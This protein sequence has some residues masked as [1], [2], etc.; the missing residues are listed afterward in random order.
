M[1][2]HEAQG[3]D[4]CSREFQIF[5]KPAGARCNLRCCYCYYLEKDAMREGSDRFRM[6]DEVLEE[7]V[8]QH[9]EASRGQEIFFSWHGGE[10]ALAG[11]DFFRSVVAIQ[12]RLVPE[13]CRVLNGMQT[14]ATLIDEAWGRFLREEDFYVGISLDGPERF[15]NSNRKKVDGRGTFAEVMRGLSVL[16][17]HDVP[18]EIL[19]VVNS[20]NA[21]APLEVY[22]FFKSLDASFIT[23]L[24][25]VERQGYNSAGVTARSVRPADFG[26]FLSAIFDEWV[27]ND[28][29]KIKVQIFEEALRTAFGQEHT[30]CIFKPVC[31]AVPVVEMNGDF[32]SCDHFVDEV[33]LIGNIMDSSLDSLL[34]HPRQKAFGE[35]KKAT[36]PNYCIDCDVLEMCN[37]ECPKNRF[38]AAPDGEPGLNYLCEGY[39]QFFNHCRP[40][41]SEVAKVWKSAL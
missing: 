20:E 27:E 24:P 13:G 19:C 17:D 4:K 14:N 41:V 9:I 32:Y 28:I 31:G 34:D 25:L 29:G 26:R 37:G 6:K 18:H 2:S 11:I 10:P 7:Y 3:T 38:L 22:R 36:L 30:L 35:A 15:H 33:H 40:F 1:N 5:V 16:R 12:K 39:R 23:F 21:H 8:R